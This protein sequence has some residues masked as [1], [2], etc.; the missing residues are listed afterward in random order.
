MPTVHL[1]FAEEL[2]VSVFEIRYFK[3][4]VK[5]SWDYTDT[6]LVIVSKIF[7]GQR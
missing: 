6:G 2:L 4:I 3:I 1:P 5:T 7:S